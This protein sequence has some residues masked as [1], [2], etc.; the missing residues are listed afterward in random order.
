[1]IFREILLTSSIRNVWRTVR[2]ICISISG[3]KGLTLFCKVLLKVADRAPLKLLHSESGLCR[4]TVGAQDCCF[5]RAPN[6]FFGIRDLT[7]LKIRIRY[8]KGKGKRDSGLYFEQDTGFSGFTMQD[9]GN[10][11]AK[12]RYAVTKIE[13]PFIMTTH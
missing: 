4:K 12:N 1:M 13:N 11:V 7:Y 9:S 2:R 6:R 10:V 3:L 5:L 8:F